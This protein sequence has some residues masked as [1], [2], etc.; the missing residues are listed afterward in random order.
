MSDIKLTKNETKILYLARVNVQR[1]AKLGIYVLTYGF[2][3]F[4]GSAGINLTV[5]YWDGLC[6]ESVKMVCT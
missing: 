6:T 1:S 2:V 3:V 4:S 5:R